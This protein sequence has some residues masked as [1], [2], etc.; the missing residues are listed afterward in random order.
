MFFQV[1]RN[2]N[3]KLSL[4]TFSYFNLAFKPLQAM[5]HEK[6]FLQ[7]FASSVALTETAIL[8]KSLMQANWIVWDPNSCEQQRLGSA[9]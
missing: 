3:I 1:Y 5:D 7:A 9:V 4:N 6:I 2:T 8:P